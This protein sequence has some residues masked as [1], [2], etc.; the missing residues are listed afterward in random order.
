MSFWDDRAGYDI[1]D[2]K[3]PY[4]ADAAQ[5]LADSRSFRADLEHERLRE[6]EDALVD[7][8]DDFDCGGIAA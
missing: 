7:G 4:H 2:V 5:G 6:Q 8:P 3:H 1:T